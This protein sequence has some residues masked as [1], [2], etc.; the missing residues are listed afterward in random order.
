[1][2]ERNFFRK[3]GRQAIRRELQVDIFGPQAVRTI[4]SSDTSYPA[5]L[6]GIQ[7]PLPPLWAYF[8]PLSACDICCQI[9]KP[10]RLPVL[11]LWHVAHP[12][13]KLGRKY[14]HHLKGLQVFGL[15][16]ARREFQQGPENQQDKSKNQSEIENQFHINYFYFLT[17]I[18]SFIT[19]IITKVFRKR[20]EERQ[21]YRQVRLNP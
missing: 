21:F 2:S 16:Q 1:M 3:D 19:A 8:L 13:V 4:N 9:L 17:G 14:Q 6:T 7:H 5:N 12:L 10:L 15:Q 20:I 11:F 18:E